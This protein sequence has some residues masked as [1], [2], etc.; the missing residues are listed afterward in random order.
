MYLKLKIPLSFVRNECTDSNGQFACFKAGDGRVNEQPQLTV[1][2]TVWMREHN[3]I[4]AALGALNPGWSDEAVFQEAR[5]IVVAELQHVTYNE[6]LPIILGKRRT[7][8][9]TLDGNFAPSREYG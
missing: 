1:M 4:A 3:R 8:K 7:G 2:H 9:L 6:W 5:R